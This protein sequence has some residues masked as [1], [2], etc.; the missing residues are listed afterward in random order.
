[1][2]RKMVEEDTDWLDGMI[3]EAITEDSN[4]P[5]KCFGIAKG[6]YN[7]TFCI[8]RCFVLGDSLINNVVT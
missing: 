6:G 4:L 7:S 1:M 5:N 8:L 3:H 2:A